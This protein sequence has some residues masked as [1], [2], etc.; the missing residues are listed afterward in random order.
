MDVCLTILAQEEN[1]KPQ[2]KARS[3]N[4]RNGATRK[5]HTDEKSD[6]GKWLHRWKNGV[7]EQARLTQP[8]RIYWCD[9]SEE[10]AH[11]LIEIGLKEEKNLRSLSVLRTQPETLAQRI[12]APQSSDRRGSD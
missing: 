12:L 1:E 8:D 5:L 7:E 11:R 2:S 4:H 10:E 6:K 3:T 9:G